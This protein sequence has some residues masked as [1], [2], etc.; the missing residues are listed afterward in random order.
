MAL[1]WM[2]LLLNPSAGSADFAELRDAYLSRFKP[3]WLEAS[4]AWWEA[5]VT[6]DDRAFERK[7]KAETAL[8]ELH[9]DPQAFAAFRTLRDAG[10]VT[11]PVAARELDVIYRAYLAGQGDPA[12]HKRIIDI[13]NDVEQVFNGHR[14]RIGD[15]EVSENEIRAILAASTDSAECE[16]AWKAYMQVGQKVDSKLRE[17]VALRNNLARSLGF[18]NFYSMQLVLQ[19]IDERELVALFDELDRL[20][21]EPFTRLKADLDAARA[22]RFGIRT[23]DLRPWH[24]TD[25]FFQEAP[26]GGAVDFDA[27]YADAD[28][29]ALTRDYYASI[30]LPCDDVLAR[31]DLYEKPGKSPHAFCSDLDREGDIRV[32]C[33]IRPNLYWA[34]TVLHEVGHAV[35][36]KYIRRDVP[37]L[38]REASHPIT[39][40]GVAMMFGAMALNEDFLVRVRRIDA[41]RAAAV[42]AAARQTQRAQKLIFCQWAQVM[43]RFERGMYADPQQDLGALWWSLKKRYQGLNPPEVTSRPDYAAKVHILTSPVYYH[44]YLMGELFAAQVKHRLITGVL[45]KPDVR[46]TCL[47][48][49][50]KAGEWLR[51]HVLGP[52]N[53]HS[54]N[55]LTR[56]ATGEPLRAQRYVDEYVR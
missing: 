36:D 34:D 8:S 20:T 37:W 10:A 28:I 13:Q 47:Y 3:L 2:L 24:Y 9:A 31:S 52:G 1:V 33:N 51:E 19:E 43:M 46:S 22:E 27:L 17:L 18:A 26:A 38:L 16:A 14:G 15:R 40:E 53:L 21:R 45:G 12:L 4:H 50:P 29:L 32:L 56:R 7:K 25:L 42:A 44:N 5:N 39:T 41:G 30:G 11:D 48:G 49:E 35:Y 55:E 23:D 6:G 54:W